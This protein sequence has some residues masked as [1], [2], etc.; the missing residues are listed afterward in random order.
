MGIAE[1]AILIST[2]SALISLG[3]VSVNL[4]NAIHDNPRLQISV[5]IGLDPRSPEAIALWGG[6]PERAH[7]GVIIEIANVGRN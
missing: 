1:I 5:S 4:W 7:H 6:D 2:L 3:S